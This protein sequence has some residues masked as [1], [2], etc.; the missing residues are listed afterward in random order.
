[1]SNTLKQLLLFE[2]VSPKLSEILSYYF[3]VE[4]DEIV[5]YLT[6]EDNFDVDE[7]AYD[8]SLRVTDMLDVIDRNLD[9]R[10]RF[11]VNEFCKCNSAFIG[12]T[13]TITENNRSL[14][15]RLVW[16]IDND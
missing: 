4:P 13:V 6:E 3:E 15:L 2:D 12:S 10:V 9:S 11:S 8:N 14:S 16:G 7:W 5:H 1:M